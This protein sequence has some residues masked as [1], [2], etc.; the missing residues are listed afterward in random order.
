MDNSN[1][2]N[3][4]NSFP[5]TSNPWQPTDNTPQTSTVQPDGNITPSPAVS[6]IQSNQSFNTPTIPMDNTPSNPFSNSVSSPF[7][8]PNPQSMPSDVPISPPP[9]DTGSPFTI[10][11]TSDVAGMQ[12]PIPATGVL[13]VQPSTNTIPNTSPFTTQPTMDNQTNNSFDNAYAPTPELDNTT[14]SPSLPVTPFESQSI[15][16]MPSSTP[17]D[18]SN[19]FSNT[20]QISSNPSMISTQNSIPAVET[21]FDTNQTNASPFATTPPATSSDNPFPSFNPS[22]PPIKN[23][24][25]FTQTAPLENQTTINTPFGIGIPTNDPIN[26][27]LATTPISAAPFTNDTSIP[28]NSITASSFVP[29]NTN[30]AIPDMNTPSMPIDTPSINTTPAA[31]SSMP[32]SSID[33]AP[34]DLSHLINNS[35]GSVSQPA[36]P[37]PFTPS[38][39]QPEALIVPTND[40]T[41]ITPTMP[42]E[43][44]HR[45]IPK[46]AIGLGVAL[47]VA[48]AGASGYFILG[49]GQSNQENTTTSIPAIE[50]QA[51]QLATPPAANPLGTGDSQ[52]PDASN[53]L[54]DPAT[55]PNNFGALESNSSSAPQATSAAELIRQRQQQTQ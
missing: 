17:M 50:Q 29:E 18:S 27:G 6:D 10:N 33:T 36:D 28:Q 41:T 54:P 35:N 12:S 40:A 16:T 47:L 51:P 13:P 30:N 1:N 2:N 31:S 15:P 9:A 46:W 3:P 19:M 22:T 48:V 20:A 21:P 23:V 34:T 26:G 53:P 24:P 45:S 43:G 38:M 14:T 32:I 5:P 37:S 52:S 42:I 55:G 39:T 11:Q 44:E 8:A 4:N 25:G 49:I 7:S